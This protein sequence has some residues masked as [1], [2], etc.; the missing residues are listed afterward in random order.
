MTLTTMPKVKSSAKKRPLH[1]WYEKFMAVLILLNYLVVIFD[2][3]YIPLRDF[4]LQGKVQM[5]FVKFNKPVNFLFFTVDN[6]EVKFP[7]KRPLKLLPTP[8]SRWL[9]NTYDPIK[10]IVPYRSTEGYRALVEEL[11]EEVKLSINST[12]L[13]QP[14]NPAETEQSLGKID[15]ILALL[16]AESVDMV[17]TNPFQIAN[18]TG[19]LER[20]KNEITEH[21]FDG[22]N[23]DYS[24]KEA[25]RTFWSKDYLFRDGIESYNEEI[26]FYDKN[27]DNLL[28]T[29]Y[30]RPIGENGKPVDNFGAFDFSF[31][32]LFFVEFLVR[33]WFIRR[34]HAGLGWF[35][36]M[37][38]RWYDVFLFI[39]LFRWLR[40][41][42]LTIRLNQVKLIN[43][44]SIQRQASQ[45]FVASI[46]GD[47]TE[48]VV[49][50]IIN[51]F[52]GAIED[53]MLQDVFE[54]SSTNPYIDLNDTDEIT[55]IIKLVVNLTV[56]QVLPE[57]QPEAEAFLKYNL[58]KS[59]QQAPAYQGIQRIPG[60]KSLETQLTEQVAHQM[61]ATLCNV[62][63]DITKSDPVFDELAAKLA[64]SFTH[65]MGNGLK[66]EHSMD[67]L[68]VLV[69]DL[70]EEVKVNYVQQL[71]EEDVED[72][73]EQTRKL[74][75][76][77]KNVVTL[78]PSNI[79]SN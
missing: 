19:T 10:G 8:F 48:V 57:I 20:I 24:S 46:A 21:V 17:N 31:G 52:Q 45:G 32:F 74:R 27:I 77:Q 2:L 64:E 12:A 7:P 72:I 49:L 42:P 33:T 6:L 47:I 71:S 18:K 50:R 36:A 34:R 63:V 79:K 4:W 75:Q 41:I 62:L 78:T 9:T 55:E 16:R 73:L 56:H 60:F 26:D 58:D 30:F 43:L 14:D 61:Y 37:L 28:E 15:D 3:T 22:T 67:R 51:Q 65:A 54:Q 1:S 13:F 66:T 40:I 53:G 5:V 38:W 68:E 35:D 76:T 39:P 69:K 29:N 44:K 59:I 11:K 23:E 25:F 70:L